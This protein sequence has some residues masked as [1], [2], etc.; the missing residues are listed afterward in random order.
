[1]ELKISHKLLMHIM[2]PNP[3]FLYVLVPD[4]LRGLIFSGPYTSLGQR[5]PC[6]ARKSL[7]TQ[8][9][10]KNVNFFFISI[11]VQVVLVY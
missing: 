6:H 5:M 7:R 11:H 10:E 8:K 2:H 4:E 3:H 9:Q 1:M